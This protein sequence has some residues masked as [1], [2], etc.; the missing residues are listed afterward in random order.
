MRLTRIHVPGPLTA[1]S[2]IV[3]PEQAGEHLARVLRLPPGA[4][5]TLFNGAGGEFSAALKES[6]GKRICAHVLVHTPVERESPLQITLLQGVARGERMDLIVQK[7][8][9]L[10]VTRIIPVLAERSVVKLDAKQRARKREHWQAI[11]ISACEQCGRNRVPEVAE[12]TPLGDSLAALD[13]GGLRCLL[14]ADGPESLVSAASRAAM[15]P[16]ALLIGPEG[17]L[18]ENERAFA[19]ANRFV[20]CRLGPRIM[21]TETA[22][23]AALAAL[24]AVSGDLSK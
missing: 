11:A 19:Q 7:A 2:D 10:G 3:L 15:R 24:Q 14:A 23:L 12:P 20:A 17:G 18:A 9:E 1:G 16:I 8:T 13:E 21:R 4:P 22:G 6:P 5:F